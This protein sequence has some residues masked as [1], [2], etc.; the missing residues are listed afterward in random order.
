MQWRELRV[1][2][3]QNDRCFWFRE[4]DD[5]NINYGLKR[6]FNKILTNN[7]S[8][9]EKYVYYDALLGGFFKSKYKVGSAILNEEGWSPT[10]E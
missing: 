4:K 9:K 2:V 1:H 5:P 3:R 6:N 10:V 8:T 7:K